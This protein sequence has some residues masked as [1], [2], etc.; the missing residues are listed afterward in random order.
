MDR[1]T[2]QNL[3]LYGNNAMSGQQGGG[4]GQN[5]Y[6]SGEGGQGDPNQMAALQQQ[7]AAAS[8]YGMLGMGYMGGAAAHAQAAAAMAEQR[9]YPQE[10]MMPGMGGGM[11][12]MNQGPGGAPPG[13][14]VG[15]GGGEGQEN[16]LDAN[17]L[18]M[19]RL[20][21]QQG[22][23]MGGMPPQQWMNYG[24]PNPDQQQQGM[25]QE[26]MQMPQGNPMMPGLGPW[27]STSAGL[28]GKMNP[29]EE[30]KKTVRKK[31]K[32]KPKRPLSAYNI[33][34][35][36]ERKRILESIPSKGEEGDDA[37]KEEE[38]EEN[39]EID[40]KTG[41][42]KRKKTPHGKIGFENLAK[43]IGQRW[44][45]LKEDKIAYYKDLAA[46]D[47]KRYKE[48]MEIFLTK[49]EAEK[50][51][52]N[53]EA[54]D[55]SEGGETAQDNGANDDKEPQAKKQKTEDGDQSS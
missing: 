32:D 24:M 43:I 15:Q 17:R 55:E 35:K 30:K 25:P 48:Q 8:Q 46:Q 54:V 41:K 50:K 37:S 29:Q 20:G 33:F 12:G 16:Y 3:F 22:P 19:Q 34:F 5:Q 44:Q 10:G 14:G 36:E 2:M 38:S 28:L 39:V 9:M 13:Q 4:N 47:M 42:K 11:P 31:H 45:E 6:G 21:N 23:G 26:G 40:E 1:A 49:Q 53:G 18:F 52:K 51:K 27:S 7:A